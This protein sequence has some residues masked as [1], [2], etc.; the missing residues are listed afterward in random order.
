LNKIWSKGDFQNCTG[1]LTGTVDLA[2]SNKGMSAGI[3]RG[4]VMDIYLNKYLITFLD[5][6]GGFFTSER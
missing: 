3:I 1:L 4:K 2:E 5:D 6:G